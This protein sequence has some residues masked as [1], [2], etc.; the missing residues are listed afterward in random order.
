MRK[1]K[2]TVQCRVPSW[3]FCNHDEYTENLRYSKK[4][5]RFCT[6][7]KTG[8]HCMLHDKPLAADSNFIY[9]TQACIDATAGYAITADE[10]T[11][12]GPTVNPKQLMRE[13]IKLYNKTVADLVAQGYPRPVAEKIAQ[14][15]V[16]DSK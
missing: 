15:Y 11:P 13:T 2:L 6:K 7:D 14:Q 9:K 3:G 12:Q 16:V 8:H 10:P 1:I 5:C 4:L